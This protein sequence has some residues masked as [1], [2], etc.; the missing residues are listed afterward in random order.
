MN[1]CHFPVWRPYAH[2]GDFLGH[3]NTCFVDCAFCFGLSIFCMYFVL[4]YQIKKI[5]NDINFGRRRGT[6]K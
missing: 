3:V 5:F 2:R 1:T 6:I 4:E